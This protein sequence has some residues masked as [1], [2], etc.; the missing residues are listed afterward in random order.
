[1]NRITTTTRRLLA[2]ICATITA[3][4]VPATAA[5]ASNSVPVGGLG[6][7]GR[8]GT[9]ARIGGLR[10]PNIPPQGVAHVVTEPAASG[11]GMWAVVLICVA[12]LMV[13]VAAAEGVRALHR[14]SSGGKLA[15][16]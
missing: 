11:L 14:R 13:G 8:L 3:L 1:M 12:A 4:I 7:A 9:H 10:G 5:L 16:A 2:V 15:T 6:A